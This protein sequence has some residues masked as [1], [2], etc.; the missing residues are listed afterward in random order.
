MKGSWNFRGVDFETRQQHSYGLLNGYTQPNQAIVQNFKTNPCDLVSHSRNK[1]WYATRDLKGLDVRSTGTF[2]KLSVF[3][4][5]YFVMQFQT[6]LV[7]P[8]LGWLITLTLLRW[9]LPWPVWPP[10]SL[11]R[12][13]R[14]ASTLCSKKP[15]RAQINRHLGTSIRYS[16]V[17]QP[18]CL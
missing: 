16:I 9:A 14:W 3:A 11:A 18:V 13:G 6:C 12:L 5:A 1:F 8:S 17:F 15:P 7:I 2:V 4:C 10:G